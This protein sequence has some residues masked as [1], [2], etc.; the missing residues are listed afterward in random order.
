[1]KQGRGFAITGGKG[2]HLTFANRW[3]VSVQ[4][5]P[6]NYCD[7]Y[8]LNISDDDVKA[9][10]DGSTTAEVACWP[11]GG[12]LASMGSDT[13]AGHQTPDQVARLIGVV[14]GLANT[15]Q[16]LPVYYL[17]ERNSHVD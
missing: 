1:M 10:R 3:T 15:D 5:G 17:A 11:E 2:F 7:N 16:E 4:F 13:V 8:D 6:G 14:A 9:G 12:E